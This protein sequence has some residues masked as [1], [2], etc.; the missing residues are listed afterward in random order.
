MHLLSVWNHTVQIDNFPWILLQCSLKAERI[1]TVI[2]QVSNLFKWKKFRDETITD[3]VSDAAAEKHLALQGPIQ[4]PGQIQMQLVSGMDQKTLIQKG[5][6]KV[7]SVQT[8][9]HT[10]LPLPS[11][12]FSQ[13]HSLRLTVPAA[14]EASMGPCAA[15]LVWQLYD[16]LH[17]FCREHQ[18]YKI[19][20]FPKPPES[21]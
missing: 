17:R 10:I 8:C 1:S 7:C 5:G 11:R 20:S 9:P 4:T 14:L 6:T 15:V 19:C 18:S 3:A 21:I 2:H 13:Q 12:L 16:V